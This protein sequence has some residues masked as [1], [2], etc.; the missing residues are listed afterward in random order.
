MSPLPQQLLLDL[1]IA[2]HVS[3]ETYYTGD[4]QAL[5]QALQQPYTDSNHRFIYIW[6]DEGTGRSHLLQASCCAAIATGTTACYIPL[7]SEQ[8]TSDMM[9]AI[10]AV[11]V[12]CWD[13][14]DVIAGDSQW[15]EALFDSYNRVLAESG[16]RLIVAANKP[17]TALDIQLPDLKSRLSAGLCFY[18][19]PLSDN[20][21]I[22]LMV[23]RAKERGLSLSQSVA[24]YLIQHYSRRL[25]DLLQCL[26]RLDQA[27]LQTQRKLTI[28]F[29]KEIL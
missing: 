18:I 13:D 22:T 28:P 17:P 20:D 4:N 14:I 23:E 10:E 8:V 16:T 1:T 11:T 2:N 29:V 24:H 7:Q 21:K 26:D 5:V 6:G 19:K 15:E 12:V 27:S 25:M 3:F 9:H